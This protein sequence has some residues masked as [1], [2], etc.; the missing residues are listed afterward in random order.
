MVKKKLLLLLFPNKYLNLQR[1]CN[2]FWQFQKG[3][4]HFLILA[5]RIKKG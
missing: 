3:Y 5:E 2:A 4:V 1:W